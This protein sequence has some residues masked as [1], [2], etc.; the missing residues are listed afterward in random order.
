MIDHY[1]DRE[2]GVLVVRPTGPLSEADFRTLTDVVDPYILE[3]GPLR[4]LV[5][6]TE[7]FPGWE[8]LFGMIGH[9]RFVRDHY[10]HIRRIALVSDSKLAG[11]VPRIGEHF[12]SAELKVY[13]Y[14][15][16]DAATE[17]VNKG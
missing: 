9:L 10:R 7:K 4:G 8:D 5:V 16:L 11:L 1:L 3:T 6:H 15:E 17:W 12:L 13:S 14:R 2:S